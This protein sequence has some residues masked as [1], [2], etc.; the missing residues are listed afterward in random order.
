MHIC[1]HVYIQ[2]SFIY[3]IECCL[4][5]TFVSTRVLILGFWINPKSVY[6]NAKQVGEFVFS[7]NDFCFQT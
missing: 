4:F 5:E 2:N 1:I 6:L 3:K 7:G